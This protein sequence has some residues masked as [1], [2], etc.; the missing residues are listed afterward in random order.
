MGTQFRRG[1][2]VRVK[3]YGGQIIER[4]VVADLGKS[5]V[6]CARGEYEAAA[7]EGREPDGVGFPKCD[8]SATQ[9]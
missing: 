9:S 5:V 4:K 7:V 1:Q 8:V 3:V 2:T 6:I